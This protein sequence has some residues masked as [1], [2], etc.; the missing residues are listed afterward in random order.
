VKRAERESDDEGEHGKK[1]Y[2]YS[3]ST[4]TSGNYGYCL[5]LPPTDKFCPLLSLVLMRPDL[6]LYIPALD[7]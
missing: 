6:C 7:N 5:S 3:Y 2:K 1:G 4:S